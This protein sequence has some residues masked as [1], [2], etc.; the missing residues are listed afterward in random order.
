MHAKPLHLSSGPQVSS[1]LAAD[2]ATGSSEGLVLA[3]C[4]LARKNVYPESW[5]SCW[6]P[7]W[8]PLPSSPQD[9]LSTL[10][11]TEPSSEVKAPW[12]LHLVLGV[13]KASLP[14]LAP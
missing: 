9:I 10:L 8:R 11:T 5:W 1:T 4:E 12:S 7:L 13:L 14:T 2:V 6:L 3:Q